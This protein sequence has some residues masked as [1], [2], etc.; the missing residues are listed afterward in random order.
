MT[1]DLLLKV[2]AHNRYFCQKHG[3][4]KV[5]DSD[6]SAM[7][8]DDFNEFLG[9]YDP[10]SMTSTKTTKPAKTAAEEFWQG[11]KKDVTQFPIFTDAKYFDSW[12]TGFTVTANNQ[13]IGKLVEATYVVPTDPEE[14]EEFNAKD[15]FLYAALQLSKNAEFKNI[16]KKH[17]CFWTCGISPDRGNL[18]TRNNQRPRIGSGSQPSLSTLPRNLERNDQ[19]V[20]YPLRDLGRKPT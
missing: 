14:L 1:K 2:A 20:P 13:G 8:S 7:T 5:K 18:D 16:V 17:N 11:I 4:T 3:V 9:C 19:P 15:N 12:N 6:W 10:N